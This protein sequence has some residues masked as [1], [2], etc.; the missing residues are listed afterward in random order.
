MWLT[1]D[2]F[3]TGNRIYWTLL[4]LW[5]HFTDHC[6]TKTS[7]LSHS[8]HCSAWQRL[9]TEDVLSLPSPH[10][11][12]LAVISHQ[13]PTLLH[14]VSRLSLDRLTT[15]TDSESTQTLLGL[16]AMAAGSRHGPHREHSFQQLFYCC[17]HVCCSH[18]LAVGMFAE[19]F[20]SNGCLCWLHNSG[21]Q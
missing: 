18:C 2:G 14:A 10:A 3:W 7:V 6:H 9:P 4:Q 16:T 15:W 17:P 1:V 13:P 19:P 21:F 12:R 11:C 5:L 20:P 8:L